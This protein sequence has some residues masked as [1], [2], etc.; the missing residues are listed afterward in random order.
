VR[1]SRDP[2]VPL[3]QVSNKPF[4]QVRDCRQV[5]DDLGDDNVGIG[6]IG[7]IGTG[8]QV[9][10]EEKNK[11]ERAIDL[12]TGSCE[13]LAIR[14]ISESPTTNG[15]EKWP[16]VRTCGMLISGCAYFSTS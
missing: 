8:N 7:E 16:L 11:S 12:T 15:I 10:G 14:P 9:V 6:T 2:L 3:V 1:H 4:E 5:F 13:R